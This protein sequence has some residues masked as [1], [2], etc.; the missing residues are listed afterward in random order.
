MIAS[1]DGMNLPQKKSG[2]GKPFLNKLSLNGSK[3]LSTSEE[4]YLETIF[5]MEQEQKTV[6]VSEIASRVGVQRPPATR[7]VQALQRKGFVE[8][9]ARCEVRL[10]SLGR[11]IAEA[12]IHRHADLFYL[13]VQVFGVPPEIAEADTCKMEHGISPHTAQRLHEFLEHYKGL[14]GNIRAHLKAGKISSAFQFLPHGKGS[15]WRA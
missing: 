9:K 10:T 1:I 6:L 2:R 7:A 12:L 8:H 3:A 11:S 13:L 15:G 5:H 4:D 14:G